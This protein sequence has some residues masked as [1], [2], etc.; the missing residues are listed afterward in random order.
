MSNGKLIV[1]LSGGLGNQMFQYAAGKALALKYDKDLFVDALTGFARDKIY[2]RSFDLEVFPIKAKIL[3]RRNFFL[4]VT[5]KMQKKVDPKLYG[6]KHG[7]CQNVIVEMPPI[8]GLRYLSNIK[9]SKNKNYRMYGY[10]QSEK[11]F[12]DYVSIMQNEFVLPEPDSVRV[13]SLG[14]KLMKSN[15]VAVG[16]RLYEES[17]NPNA[18]SSNGLPLD[19]ASIREKMICISQVEKNVE[20]YVFCTHKAQIFESV[21]Q[22]LNVRYMVPETGVGDQLDALWLF[23]LCRT[24]IVTNSSFYWWGAW[25]AHDNSSKVYVK[26]NFIN[27]DCIPCHWESF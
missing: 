1:Q 16:I 7:L 4:E 17:P 15:S 22:G 11:Y 18:H 12:E 27:E 6:V 14:S 19:L 8:C 21:F 20:F 5:R 2:Q 9:L 13:Q 3:K 26:D 10:W 23:S 25:L 24:H